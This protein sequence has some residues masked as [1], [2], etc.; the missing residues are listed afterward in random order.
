MNCR[1]IVENNLNQYSF[2]MNTINPIL[3]T[4]VVATGSYDFTPV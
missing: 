2:L 4:T 3:T 1:H